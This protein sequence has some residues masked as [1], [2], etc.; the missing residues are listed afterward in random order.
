VEIQNVCFSP[1]SSRSRK[2]KKVTIYTNVKS[3]VYRT[4][5]M[6]FSHCK[7]KS[8]WATGQQAASS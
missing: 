4:S 8:L 3:A 6:T 2:F 7:S 1:N 5:L